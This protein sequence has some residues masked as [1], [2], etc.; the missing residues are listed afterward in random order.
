MSVGFRL[1]NLQPQLSGSMTHLKKGGPQWGLQ[2][3]C[4]T[5][6]GGPGTRTPTL[7]LILQLNRWPQ[8]WHKAIF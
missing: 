5:R 8:K 6:A 3:D 4:G 2:S 1:V 7:V